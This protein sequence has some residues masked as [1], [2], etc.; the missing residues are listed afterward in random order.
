M[1]QKWFKQD[2]GGGTIRY[3]LYVRSTPHETWRYTPYFIDAS[4]RTEQKYAL[5]GS[6]MGDLVTRAYP[7]YRIAAYLGGLDKLADAKQKAQNLYQE[8]TQK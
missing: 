6:G 2:V 4:H 8:D 7:P 5:Y 1:L 3:R